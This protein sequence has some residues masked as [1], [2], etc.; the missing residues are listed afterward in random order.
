M[1]LWRMSARFLPVSK[2]SRA[3]SYAMD[4][5]M[6]V[7]HVAYRDVLDD[8]EAILKDSST[9]GPADLCDSTLSFMSH[10]IYM[11]SVEVPKGAHTCSR[12]V[13]RWIFQRWRSGVSRRKRSPYS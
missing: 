5:I 9:Y 13:V 11:R 12:H 1:Q 6:A 7:G 4:S 3:A 10:L 8:V 2:T